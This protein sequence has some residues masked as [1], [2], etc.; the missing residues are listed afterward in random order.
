MQCSHHIYFDVELFS[1]SNL[2]NAATNTTMNSSARLILLFCSTIFYLTLT[3]ALFIV[4]S[5]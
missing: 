3:P 2:I 4:A 5:L 1:K